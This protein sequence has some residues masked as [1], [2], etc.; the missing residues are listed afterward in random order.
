MR[1]TS[2]ARPST[3]S[4]GCA[5]LTLRYDKSFSKRN[6]AFLQNVRHLRLRFDLEGARGAE[7]VTGV[8]LHFRRPQEGTVE[9]RPLDDSLETWVLDHVAFNQRGEDGALRARVVSPIH[10]VDVPPVIAFELQ[11]I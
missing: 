1:S 11:E 6:T 8:V 2:S 10:L 3:S 7:L 9:I 5:L 4:S